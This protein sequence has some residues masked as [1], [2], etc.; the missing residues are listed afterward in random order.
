MIIVALNWAMFLVVLSSS[1][2]GR[3][4]VLGELHG[5]LVH[6]HEQER[7]WTAVQAEQYK[8]L[9]EHLEELR[10]ITASQFDGTVDVLQQMGDRLH[11]D[12]VRQTRS[13]SSAISSVSVSAIGHMQLPIGSAGEEIS[14][15]DMQRAVDEAVD[16][17][18][19]RRLR[20]WEEQRGR[21]KEE[22]E[23]QRNFVIE[24]SLPEVVEVVQETSTCMTTRD[25]YYDELQARGIES[26]RS[27]EGKLLF[28]HI[29]KTGGTS[30]RKAIEDKYGKHPRTKEIGFPQPQNGYWLARDLT[31]KETLEISAYKAIY[32][33]FSF[34]IHSLFPPPMEYC[35]VTLLRE[36]VSRIVSLFYY[37]QHFYPDPRNGKN[38]E[39]FMSPSRDFQYH[40]KDNGM[41]RALCGY[42]AWITPFK[43]LKREHLL[44]AK[45]N[46]RNYF[47]L[48]LLTERYDEGIE[49]L[50][51]AFQW[52]NPKK[53][54]VNVTPKYP[55]VD[56]HSSTLIR[57]I[58][59]LNHLDMELY[60]FAKELYEE[61]LHRFD[62]PHL[63]HGRQV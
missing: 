20:L 28:L 1:N 46:L 35:Y 61:Q 14:A 43:G 7:E 5:E 2:S 19:E 59:A 6:Q 23:E 41:T 56:E 49:L 50:S 63:H 31:A 62:V 37:I 60:E 8:R 42:P 57:Q 13:L 26:V 54:E 3:E 18:V 17:E 24:C 40:N 22:E 45:E 33:H 27:G 32:G 47:S 58:K 10:H 25:P 11:E 55:R 29:Q 16:R 52:Q 44:C 51:H 30:L 12:T 48:V 15:V 39:E 34:G 9:E 38:L 21:E 53:I 36:P 4:G